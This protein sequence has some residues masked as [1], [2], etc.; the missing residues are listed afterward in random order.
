MGVVG[1]GS[2]YGIYLNPEIGGVTQEEQIANAQR[3]SYTSYENA[4]LNVLDRI[5]TALENIKGTK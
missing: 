5:A 2:E 3:K 4:I 1:E